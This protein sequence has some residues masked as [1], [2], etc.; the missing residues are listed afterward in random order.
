MP[1][2]NQLHAIPFF[3]STGEL[4]LSDMNQ[5]FLDGIRDLEQHLFSFALRV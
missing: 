1:A 5:L 4:S 3:V 2:T